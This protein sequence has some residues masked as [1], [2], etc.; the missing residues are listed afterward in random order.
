MA[1]FAPVF[2][3]LFSFFLVIAFI[4]SGFTIYTGFVDKRIEIEKN[5]LDPYSSSLPASFKLV[6]PQFF[7]TKFE[8]RVYNN[9]GKNVYFKTKNVSCFSVFVNKTYLPET[10]VSIST[11]SSLSGTY[12]MIEKRF[13]RNFVVTN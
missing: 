13:L 1:S 7:P 9:G 11:A 4:V 8:V 3:F 10:L 2:I 6:S 5:V 12:N